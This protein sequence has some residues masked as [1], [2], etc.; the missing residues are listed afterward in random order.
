MNISDMCAG[1]KRSDA[2]PERKY[3][4]PAFDLSGGET[5]LLRKS[6]LQLRDHL[7]TVSVSEVSI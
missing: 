1:K 5:Y 3:F 7:Y 6:Y 4:V 2:K